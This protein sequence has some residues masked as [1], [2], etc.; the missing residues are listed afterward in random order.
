MRYDSDRQHR[1]SIRLR[2]YDYAQDGAYFVTI[3][4]QERECLFG[5]IIDGTMELS[6]FGRVVEDEWAK[7]SSIRPNVEIDAFV[8]MPNHFHAI[9]V[10]ASDEHDGTAVPPYAPTTV[11]HQS[12]TGE[13][14]AF[15]SPSQTLGAVV[16]G[17]KSAATRRINDLRRMPGTP[18]WQ[19]N[20]YE[21]IIR[22]E[23]SLQRIRHYIASNPR[24][25]AA[26]QLH[27]SNLS[28]W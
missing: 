3:C 7:T 20:Y 10:V 9:V 23:R 12:L 17:F 19:R 13:R 6:V 21:H 16:R 18:I 28:K 5:A 11:G 2:D 26:D 14:R 25:W 8:V 15:R 22:N 1:R 27:P 4:V 24:H